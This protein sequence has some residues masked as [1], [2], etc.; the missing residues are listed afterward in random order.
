MSLDVV[1]D[2]ILCATVANF[3][4]SREFARA[5]NFEFLKISKIAFSNFENRIE[6]RNAS[7]IGANVCHLTW[8]EM[9]FGVQPRQIIFL[10]QLRASAKLRTNFE[11][12]VFKLRKSNRNPK[13]K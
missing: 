2:L 1:K 12:H 5:Q 11:N 10:A 3:V 13:R 8:L 9:I 4:S 6:I 7:R